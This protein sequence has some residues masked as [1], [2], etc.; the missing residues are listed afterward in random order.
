MSSA[1]AH[2][3]RYFAARALPLDE[4]ANRDFQ[5]FR[6]TS[7][8]EYWPRAQFRHEDG[9]RRKLQDGPRYPAF[10]SAMRLP[11][12]QISAVHMTFLS[13]LGPTKL[14]VARDENSKIMFGEAKGAMIRIS[15][16]P[17]GKPPETALQAYPLILCEG[18][19]DGLSLARAVPE[20]RVWAA[21]S[22]S[23]MGSAPIWL[24]CIS[25]VIVAQDNDFKPTAQKQFEKALEAL[26]AA[27]PSKAITTIASHMGKDF[28]DLIKED[29]D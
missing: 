10:L 1:E 7:E 5:T 8:Q 13:P 9:R 20:A 11:T 19:E 16:G 26:Q 2:A 28:N 23:A 29:E 22:L 6:F 14:P 18:V 24:P 25:G 3:R 4:I 27:A 17:E 12:G 21:G 15:H